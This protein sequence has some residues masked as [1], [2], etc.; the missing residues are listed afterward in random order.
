MAAGLALAGTFCLPLQATGAPIVLE[1]S[2]GEASAGS[3]APL[4]GISAHVLPADTAWAFI[5][6]S[7]TLTLPTDAAAARV[8]PLLTGAE[9]LAL[10][11][12]A[13]QRLTP[14][15]A[16]RVAKPETCNA[17]EVC[18]RIV[19]S[20]APGYQPLL[21]SSPSDQSTRPLAPAL[22]VAKTVRPVWDST[23]RRLL[24][25]FEPE[26]EH[27]ARTLLKVILRE[28]GL[29]EIARDLFQVL[30]GALMVVLAIG[31]VTVR[32][33]KLRQH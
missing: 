15:A 28:L 31:I 14:E 8:A 11:T 24:E 6:D 16:T 9:A 30:V 1:R 20:V 5:L 4:A 23:V 21:V 2:G 10:A 18:Q 33:A 19:S 12:A 27:P 25:Q 13:L 22:E 26:R 7:S 3:V 17:S 32:V 29:L